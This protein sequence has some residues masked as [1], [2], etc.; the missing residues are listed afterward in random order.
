MIVVGNYEVI[1]W[2]TIT[3][4]LYVHLFQMQPSHI[5]TYIHIC[6][7]VCIHTYALQT[8]LPIVDK[9]LFYNFTLNI[10]IHT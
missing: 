5:C 3:A 6:N 1:I 8:W 9:F 2:D 7:Y 4:I 10:Y